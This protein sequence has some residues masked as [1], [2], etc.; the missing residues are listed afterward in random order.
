MKNLCVFASL[1]QSISFLAQTDSTKTS[2]LKLSA[3]GE[4]YYSYDF[5]KPA[6]HNRAGFTYSHNRH[7]EINLNLGLIKAA[8]ETEY[9]RA[10]LALAAGTYMNANYFAEQD[11][12]KNVYEANI[13]VKLSKTRTIWLDA[14]IFPSHI[15]WESAIGKDNYTLTRSLA[16]DNSPYFETGAKISYT[17][18]NGKWF[19]SA[20]V[21]NGWQRIQRVDGNNSLAFGHQ[22]TYKLNDEISL[23]SSSFIGNDK[24][25]SL[26]Q[27]RYFHNL[28]GTFQINKKLAVI[29]GFDVGAEQ[30]SKGSKQY[31]SW[32]T[33][34]LIVKYLTT[35]KSSI[36]ARGEYFS[37]KNGVVVATETGYGFKT[38]GY[39]LN[40][41]YNIAKNVVWRIEGRGF[42]AKDKIF[43][44]EVDP[45]KDNFFVTTSLSI[46]F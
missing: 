7:N 14:G 20:L 8:Y 43:F 31:N 19:V 33:P 10:N 30:K 32:Y 38:F 24:P 9:V 28:Y 5:G 25:D 11:V 37:D 2:S 35:E 39:S 41:D 26:K 44:R 13:G 45:V 3:Y 23:N 1:L 46:S 36:S 15:G 27:M 16:A 29:A 18:N 42:Y 6:H 12:M 4:V 22:L 40:F 17:T 34:V 21:L